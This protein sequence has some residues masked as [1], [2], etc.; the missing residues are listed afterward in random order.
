MRPVRAWAPVPQDASSAAVVTFCGPAMILPLLRAF[1]MP[2][3]RSRDAGRARVERA[4]GRI[5]YPGGCTTLSRHVG[6]VFAIS[7]PYSSRHPHRPHRASRVNVVAAAADAVVR[8]QPRASRGNHVHT[9]KGTG[10]S[11]SRPRRSRLGSVRSR[12]PTYLRQ[13]GGGPELAVFVPNRLTTPSP[14]S[15][16]LPGWAT[17][18]ASTRSPGVSCQP[19]VSPPAGWRPGAASASSPSLVDEQP[20]HVHWRGASHDRGR[21]RSSWRLLRRHTRLVPGRDRPAAG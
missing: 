4:F 3:A 18:P 6:S 12:R 11:M 19:L 5:G 21:R 8:Y 7:A 15:L 10:R 14:N 20:G 2:R 1:Q 9:L 17:A 13:R 16:T